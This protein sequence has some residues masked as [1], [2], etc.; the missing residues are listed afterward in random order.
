MMKPGG[1]DGTMVPGRAEGTRSHGGADR[2]TSEGG[3]WAW[4]AVQAEGYEMDFL[5]N[6]RHTKSHG[7][8]GT[9]RIFRNGPF[10]EQVEKVGV[11]GRAGT[12]KSS[13]T[14]C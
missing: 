6:T 8:C 14:L 4:R 7:R 1:A 11:R 2:S 12:S 13:L 5:A 9:G 10:G 3:G